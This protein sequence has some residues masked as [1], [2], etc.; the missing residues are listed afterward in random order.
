MTTTLLQQRMQQTEQDILKR[1]EE[2]ADDLAQL[3]LEVGMDYL[4]Q[5]YGKKSAPK[6]WRQPEFWT[7]WRWVWH[8]N[9]M[10]IMG[11]VHEEKV[12]LLDF[13]KYG[14]TQL[15]KALSN[16]SVD[17]RHLTQWLK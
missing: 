13:E 6:I 15:A 10:D 2:T 17:V 9:D 11:F 8:M 3:R 7:W 4:V 1:L 5:R 16:Y 14:E 12:V